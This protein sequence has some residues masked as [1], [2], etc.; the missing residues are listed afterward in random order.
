MSVNQKKKLRFFN[1]RKEQQAYQDELTR[2]Q[3]PEERMAEA[4]ALIKMVYAKE[5]ENYCCEKR[6]FPK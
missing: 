2:K 6:I 4:V 1:S 3:S 5:L